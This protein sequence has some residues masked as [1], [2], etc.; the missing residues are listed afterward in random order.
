MLPKNNLFQ[1]IALLSGVL[2]LSGFSTYSLIKSVKPVSAVAPCII[3]IS[4]VQYDVGP[5]TVP[6]AHPGGNVFVCGTDMTALFMSMPTHAADIARMT[7]YIYVAPTATPTAT[8]TTTPTVIPTTTP[9][10]TPSPT[11]DPTVTPTA[12]P[13]IGQSHSDDHDDDIDEIEDDQNEIEE[14]LSEQSEHRLETKV[15]TEHHDNKKND[16]DHQ[17][18]QIQAGSRDRHED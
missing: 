13:T 11:V 14:E 8:P 6:G 12:T 17:N 15:E 4:G 16:S 7:P 18:P 5:L 10:V 9:T 3:T 1:N 2:V